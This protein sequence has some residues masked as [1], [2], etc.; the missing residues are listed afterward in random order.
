MEAFMKQA[1]LIGLILVLLACQTT[2]AQSEKRKQSESVEDVT[3]TTASPE[4]R[5]EIRYLL[6]VMGATPGGT[7]QYAQMIDNVF[8][9]YRK[10]FPRVPETLWMELSSEI[11][12]DFGPNKIME[13]L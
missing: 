13:V 3:T 10:Q 6:D 2:R 4:N 8:A 7:Q 1:R 5:R 11:K 12:R 9:I